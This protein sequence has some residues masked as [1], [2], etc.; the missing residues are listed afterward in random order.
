[1]RTEPPVSAASSVKA[2]PIVEGAMGMPGA[3]QVTLT[4][5]ET[6]VAPAAVA[7]PSA[8]AS[9][10]KM[11]AASPATVDPNGPMSTVKPATARESSAA[12][13]WGPGSP[14]VNGS[15]VNSAIT[16]TVPMYAC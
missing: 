7:A 4:C 2:E 12:V 6:V 14:S 11:A 16:C 13:T 5:S 10:L 1:M 3:G 15:I 8:S 9:A